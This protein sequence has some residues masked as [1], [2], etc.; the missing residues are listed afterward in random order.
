[1]KTQNSILYVIITLVGIALIGVIILLSLP[2][3]K[4]EYTT[5]ATVDAQLNFVG[6]LQEDE[7]IAL[8]EGSIVNPTTDDLQSVRV[9]VP[10]GENLPAVILI[11]GGVGNGADFEK[12]NGEYPSDVRTI[13]EAGFV[14]AVYDPLGRGKSEGEINFQGLE[15][16][17]GLS[18]VIRLVQNM[19]E[20]NSKNVGLASFSYG[21]TAAAGVLARY[22]ELAL[23]FWSDWEG[24]S[25]RSFTNPGCAGSLSNNA[26][27]TPG[28]FACND[29]E[30][31]LGR[32][33]AESVKFARVDSYWRTQT[34]DDHVQ[35][36]YGHTVE[37]V[38]NAILNPDIL[39]VFLNDM[40]ENTLVTEET[41]EPV[42]NGPHL[43]LYI[44]P[45]LK[46]MAGL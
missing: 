28:S 30:H 46:E 40:T 41:V 17:D 13:A 19:P 18:E 9:Y 32:E 39:H 31:W 3:S 45:H 37:M 43:I 36:T 29:D 25:S 35:N 15:D 24:P 8:W 21:V 5:T 22:P 33:A 26:L 14:T 42:P 20:V 4:T 27:P 23:K 11:P 34:L 44:I 7:S 38:N 12:D 10:Q 16:Q 1:M 2:D 6:P